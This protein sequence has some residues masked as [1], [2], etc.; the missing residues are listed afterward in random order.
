MSLCQIFTANRKAKAYTF[1]ITRALTHNLPGRDFERLPDK[2]ES[3]LSD[4]LGDANYSTHSSGNFK[5]S[6]LLICV[7]FDSILPDVC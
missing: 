6:P 7:N 5:V 2:T 4:T 3:S 1:N